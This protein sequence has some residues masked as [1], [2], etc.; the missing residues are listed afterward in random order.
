MNFKSKNK[1]Y[2]SPIDRF[3]KEFFAV[4]ELSESQIAV[5]AKSEKIYY[6]RD[7]AVVDTNQPLP[8]ED[9]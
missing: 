1:H 4:H 6:K 3:F 5:K 2:V 8:W 9:F 7:H